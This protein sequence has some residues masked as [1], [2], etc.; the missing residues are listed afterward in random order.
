MLKK[1]SIIFVVILFI[2]TISYAKTPDIYIEDVVKKENEEKVTMDLHLDNV[3]SNV[4]SLGLDIKYDDKKLE[5]VSSKSGKN[6][7][8]TVQIAEYEEDNKI[9]IKIMS[10]NGLKV[11]GI[12]YQVTF[13]IIDESVDE[14]PV[15]LEVKDVKD[16]SG[17]VVKC[18]VNSGIVYTDETKK[19]NT[20]NDKSDDEQVTINPFDKTDVN[21]SE[22]LDD[23]INS[24]TTPTA[25]D[26]GNL[27][28]EVK[29]GNILEILADGTMVAKEDGITQVTVKLNDEEIG[30]L[31]VETENGQIKKVSSKNETKEDDTSKN[32]NEFKTSNKVKKQ[33]VTE[34]GI[35]INPLVLVVILIIIII[36]TI[37]IYKKKYK[38]SKKE[39]KNGKVN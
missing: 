21:P 25:K 32:E 14:I 20:R 7:K 16:T 4:A 27:K 13:K 3:S 2:T 39:K 15:K 1:F 29:D 17:N 18:N 5:Y 22:S 33:S 24:N 10:S 36:I 6:L 35:K 26:K 38:K 12:Y 19:N 23:I 28:Y 8:T 37:V 30:K 34:S 31:E 11:D 9:S